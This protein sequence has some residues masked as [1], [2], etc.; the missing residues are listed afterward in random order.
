MGVTALTAHYCV[1]RAFQ[2]AD[3]LTV[4]PLDY[5]RM[6]LA[7]VIGY[8]FYQE[9]FELTLFAGAVVIIAGNFY[10]IRYEAILIKSAAK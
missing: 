7:A 10:N 1:T 4:I 2:V 5:L 8:V 9:S 3:T 6:P